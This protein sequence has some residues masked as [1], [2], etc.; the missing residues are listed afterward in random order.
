MQDSPFQKGEQMDILKEKI[1]AN[2]FQTMKHIIFLT[3]TKNDKIRYFEKEEADKRFLPI[4]KEQKEED[5]YTFQYPGEM[6]ERYEE[7]I[8]DTVQIRR[9]LAFA[10]VTMSDFHEA[11]MYVGTQYENFLKRIEREAKT[12]IYL[13]GAMCFLTLSEKKQKFYYERIKSYSYKELAECMCILFLFKGKKEIWEMLKE[14]VCSFFENERAVNIFQNAE[15]YIWFF[16]T[17]EKEIKKE[18]KQIF[19]RLKIQPFTG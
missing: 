1:D 19:S 13:A 12:D 11:Q 9:A 3:S 10:L 14:N 15:M 16:R 8:G 5:A 4:G 2:S 6:L 7:K 17:Y 18:R